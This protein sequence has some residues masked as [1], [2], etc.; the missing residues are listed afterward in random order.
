MDKFLI[1]I[2]PN[3]IYYRVDTD[4]ETPGELRRRLVESGFAKRVSY[5]RKGLVRNLQA[6]WYALPEIKIL[7]YNP[8]KN[9]PEGTITI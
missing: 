1:Q 8:K 9:N 2:G 6:P 5:P 3:Y 4:A 7:R